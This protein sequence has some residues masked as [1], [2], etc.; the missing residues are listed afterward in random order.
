MTP[1]WPAKD[2]F[3]RL[4]WRIQR[5][6]L[7]EVTFWKLLA[8]L[9][10]FW[11][12]GKNLSTD[13]VKFIK[14]CK[15]GKKLS[16]DNNIL[17]IFWQEGKNLSS[18]NMLI[19][20]AGRKTTFPLK[21]T[22]SFFGKKEKY[23]PLAVTCLASRKYIFSNKKRFV[24]FVGKKGSFLGRRNSAVDTN[25]LVSDLQPNT[26]NHTSARKREGLY[27]NIYTDIFCSSYYIKYIHTYICCCSF[28]YI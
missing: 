8:Q 15:M 22:C 5:T 2:N 17:I 23:L 6:R 7:T 14:V 18:E 24:M 10:L 20:L 25:Y 28:Y 1:G 12:V 13:H 19:I 21:T 9:W 11:Q 26:L 4:L 16:F 3:Q 27:T